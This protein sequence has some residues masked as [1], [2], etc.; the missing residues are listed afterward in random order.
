MAGWMSKTIQAINLSVNSWDGTQARLARI[1]RAVLTHTRSSILTPLQ[2]QDLHAA[3]ELQFCAAALASRQALREGRLTSLGAYM[4]QGEVWVEGRAQAADLAR[5]L[6]VPRL[7]IIMPSERLA[8]LILRSC[9]E[10][11]HRRSPQDAVARSRSIAWI[12]RASQVA[13]RVIRACP[14][15]RRERLLMREQQMGN[16][17]SEKLQVAPPLHTHVLG[18]VRPDHREG[19]PRENNVQ[20]LGGG[21]RLPGVEGSRFVSVPRL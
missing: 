17:P 8:E 12:V 14:V 9:H 19:L 20:V 11:D 10:E 1:T 13:K 21:V 15:C 4:D 6:G 7:R 5:L 2:P 18:P 16:L 3:R